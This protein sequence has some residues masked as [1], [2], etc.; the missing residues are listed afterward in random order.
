MEHQA[1]EAHTIPKGPWIEKDILVIYRFVSQVTRGFRQTLSSFY[2][3]QEMNSTPLTSRT[4]R[5]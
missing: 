4:P 2:F 1:V 5:I 3:H